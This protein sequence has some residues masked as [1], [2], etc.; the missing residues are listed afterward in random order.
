MLIQK[1]HRT[2]TVILLIASISSDGNAAG[3]RFFHRLR[4]LASD[5]AAQD[6]IIRAG[7]VT[8]ATITAVGIVHYGGVVTDHTDGVFTSIDN[9]VL[10]AERS[11]IARLSYALMPLTTMNTQDLGSEIT[12]DDVAS[13]ITALQ[14]D[15]LL[16]PSDTAFAVFYEAINA[17]KFQPSQFFDCALQVPDTSSPM[18]IRTNLLG[19]AC[20][21]KQQ[22]LVTF[23]LSQGAHRKKICLYIHEHSAAY[24]PASLVAEQE[25]E[26]PQSFNQ[27]KP[28]KPS[29]ILVK[30]ALEGG[31]AREACSTQ[32]AILRLR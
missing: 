19:L 3:R 21:Y 28:G 22:E 4:Q 16:H 13:L 24:T 29:G 26:N 10:A 11:F 9:T 7:I 18:T 12:P 2:L 17:G 1:L 23:L 15:N 8:G 20:L 6:L 31:H 25:A 30:I 5:P 14:T 27:A 32:S